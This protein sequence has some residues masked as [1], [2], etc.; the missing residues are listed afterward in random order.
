[1]SEHFATAWSVLPDYLSAHVTLSASAMALGFSL[2]FLLAIAAARSARVRWPV[3]LFASV[4]QTIPGLAL[5]ALFYPLLLALSAVSTRLFGAGFSALGFLPS[6][7]ALALYSMLPV[8]RNGVT[9][10]L[11]LD[12]ALGEAARHLPN[13][14]NQRR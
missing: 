3:L 7:L 6:L 4:V 10:I 9:G 2:S 13:E 8:I 5:L 14:Q 1:M 11:N 12:P